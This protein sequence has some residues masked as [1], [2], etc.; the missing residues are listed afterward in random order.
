M[1]QFLLFIPFSVF[2]IQ[3]TAQDMKPLKVGDHAI[4]IA[5]PDASGQI[6][7]LSS[8]KG[9]VTLVYF[10]SSGCGFC[11][12]EDK[13]LAYS[14]QEFHKKGFEMY[15]V[16]LDENTKSWTKALNRKELRYPQ[17]ID[18]A[19]MSARSVADYGVTSLP[20]NFL[21]DQYG[22]IMMVNVPVEQL[23]SILWVIYE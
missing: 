5:L 13:G 22:D 16:S 8:Y 4:E 18:T 6:H 11:L 17:V 21:I 1:R 3:L 23:F 12:K 19:G 14:Y 9:H 7:K 20:F 2:V 10:W 15:G